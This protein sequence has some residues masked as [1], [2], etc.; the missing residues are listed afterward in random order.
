M[1]ARDTWPFTPIIPIQEGERTL[2]AMMACVGVQN[3]ISVCTHPNM[4]MTVV[5][6]LTSV[7]YRLLG[8]ARSAWGQE[9]HICAGDW[10]LRSWLSLSLWP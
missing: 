4:F 5:L 2:T 8:V 7:D 3:Y 9:V 1:N 6:S 10:P